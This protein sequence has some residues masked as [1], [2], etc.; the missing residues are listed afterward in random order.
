M[1]AKLTHLLFVQPAPDS[2]TLQGVEQPFCKR[3]VLVAMA[4]EAGEELNSL[5]QERW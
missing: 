5:I 2:S 4:D 3:L 1:A